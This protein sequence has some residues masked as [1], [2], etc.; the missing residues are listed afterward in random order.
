MKTLSTLF[1]TP[2]EVSPLEYINETYWELVRLEESPPET[3]Y[4]HFFGTA[5]SPQGEDR[6]SWGTWWMNRAFDRA[7]EAAR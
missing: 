4:H 3:Q 1:S 2:S 6:Y 5:F 7:V